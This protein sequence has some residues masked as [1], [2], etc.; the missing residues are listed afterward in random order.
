MELN[1]FK[2]AGGGELEPGDLNYRTATCEA[3]EGRRIIR[4]VK[5][6]SDRL[7]LSGSSTACKA[8]LGPG[9]GCLSLVL[10]STEGICLSKLL[11]LASS[12]AR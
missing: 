5:D 7:F 9:A 12:K 10:S 4:N 3:D 11:L 1:A 8:T 6:V 2:Y